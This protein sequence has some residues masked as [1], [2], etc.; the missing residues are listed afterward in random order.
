MAENNCY[1]NY[2]TE[3]IWE[4]IVCECL[5]FYWGCPN[6]E[7]YIDELAFVRLDIS[8]PKKS[9]N[10]VKTAIKENWWEKRYK[11]IINAKNA[12]LNDI[13]MMPT[14]SKLSSNIL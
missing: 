4:P 5:C 2:A 6:L 11:H 10:I 1:D 12:I 8:D 14:I 13:G 9:L 7:S 3:K